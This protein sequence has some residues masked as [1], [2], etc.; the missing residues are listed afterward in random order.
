MRLKGSLLAPNT[1]IFAVATAL[2]RSLHTQIL[3]RRCILHSNFSR[4]KHSR[5]SAP[6]TGRLV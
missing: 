2:D 3:Q 1:T 5:L 6:M 4:N